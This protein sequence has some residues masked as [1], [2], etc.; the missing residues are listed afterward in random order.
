MSRIHY[1]RFYARRLRSAAATAWLAALAILACAAAEAPLGRPNIILV[2]LDT[3]RADHLGAYGYERPTSPCLDAIAARGVLFEDASAPSSHTVTSM[4]SLFSG[5]DPQRHGNLY[6]PATQSFR[7]PVRRVR[8]SVPAELPLLAEQ[9]AR[10][11]YRRAAVVTTPWLRE[12]CGFARGFE[13]WIDLHTGEW[14][15]HPRAEQ[16]IA[17]ARR[18]VLRLPATFPYRDAWRALALRSGAAVYDEAV[19]PSPTPTAFLPTAAPTLTPTQSPTPSATPTATGSPTDAGGVQQ[20]QTVVTRS[21]DTRGASGNEGGDVDIAASG[22]ITL[23]QIT[24]SGGAGGTSEPNRDGVDSSDELCGFEKV[25]TVP[26][27]DDDA[28]GRPTIARALMGAGFANSA[29]DAFAQDGGVEMIGE[30]A[31]EQPL[32]AISEAVV[33]IA[34]RR[35]H[36]ESPSEHLGAPARG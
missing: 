11:G 24:T 33:P 7:V 12:S 27:E 25:A 35:V 17:S 5:V 6:F 34:R 8:P 15:N 14:K 36:D 31:Q 16:V 9:L 19:V 10:A 28:L 22:N 29:E 2:V 30:P 13:P 23:G 4:L 3:L 32:H 1:R 18:L 20:T 21:V 26:P